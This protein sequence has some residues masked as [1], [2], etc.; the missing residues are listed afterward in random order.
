MPATGKIAQS[1]LLPMCKL[2]ENT[3]IGHNYHCSYSFVHSIVYLFL[4]KLGLQG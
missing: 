2:H 1:V 3:C 4:I